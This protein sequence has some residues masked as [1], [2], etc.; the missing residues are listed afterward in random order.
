[1]HESSRTVLESWYKAY[2]YCN[3]SSARLAKI[4]SDSES[5]G[6]IRDLAKQI[7]RSS[8]WIGSPRG[9]HFRLLGYNT[10][11]HQSGN[12]GC[13]KFDGTRR[14]QAKCTVSLPFIC[15]RGERFTVP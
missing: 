14:T 11:N 15:E 9:A 7:N 1:M 4:S 12:R 13:A 3:K 5:L 2:S 8:F 10:H 6:F